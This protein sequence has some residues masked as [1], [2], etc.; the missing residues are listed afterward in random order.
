MNILKP[1]KKLREKITGIK[2]ESTSSL[3]EEWASNCDTVK[4]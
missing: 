3:P 1:I 2:R 4:N